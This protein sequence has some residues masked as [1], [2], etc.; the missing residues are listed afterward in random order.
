[1]VDAPRFGFFTCMSDIAPQMLIEGFVTNLTI[2][3]F[4]IGKFIGFSDWMK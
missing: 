4:N 3:G 1:M 2:A